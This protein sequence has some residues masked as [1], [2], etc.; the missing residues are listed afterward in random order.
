MGVDNNR[1]SN[2]VV[3][4][5]K[6]FMVMRVLKDDVPDN[7]LEVRRLF[8]SVLLLR[9]FLFFKFFK[10]FLARHPLAW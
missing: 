5:V 7:S 4:P 3:S 6:A 2:Q 10:E 9:S 8:W 1:Q